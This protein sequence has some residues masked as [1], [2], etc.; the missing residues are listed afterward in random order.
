MLFNEFLGHFF[1]SRG[2]DG[3]HVGAVWR[4]SVGGG[5]GGRGGRGE[6]GRHGGGDVGPLQVM[7]VVHASVVAEAA[8]SVGGVAMAVATVVAEKWEWNLSISYRIW[9]EEIQS[10]DIDPRDGATLE[11]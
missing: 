4:G 2:V 6:R 8:V 1:I 5:A 7:L 10:R 11:P 3:V 9:T